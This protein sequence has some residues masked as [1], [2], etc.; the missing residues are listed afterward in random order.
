MLPERLAADE[1]WLCDLAVRLRVSAATLRRWVSR[2][3]VRARQCRGQHH[4][5]VWADR[6]E[7]KRLR[8]L[9]ALVEV[10][11]NAYPPELTTP[12]PGR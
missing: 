6:S 11:A 7:R 9:A 12:A 3:W 5:I 2:G 1:W 8:A 10:G 4:W